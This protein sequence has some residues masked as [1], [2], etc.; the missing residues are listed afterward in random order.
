M[1][2][3]PVIDPVALQLGPL[4]IRWYALSYVVG[5]VLGYAYVV[6]LCARH[7]PALAKEAKDNLILF[8]IIGVMLGGR[9][10]YVLFYQFGY[11]LEN[12]AHILMLW[13]GGMSF[14]GGAAGVIIAFW[15]FARKYKIPYL[16]LMD[17]IVCAVPIGLF[18]GRL[19]NFINGELFGRTT[20][21]PWAMVFPR[22]GPEPRHPSQLYEAA[23]EGLL[24]LLVLYVLQRFT[25][26][27]KRHGF[28]G[29]VFLVGYGISRTVAECFREPDVQIGFLA[30]GV[31]MGQLLCVPMVLAGAWLMLRAKKT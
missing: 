23:L 14:H 21:V 4:A 24:L 19:A 17:R 27:I 9:I 20:D 1:I 3:Y 13:Q 15:F 22:G 11:F 8:A 5:I 2:D 31:T 26:A 7:G 12:P 30:G 29:G 6:K 10:G 25:P 18:L 28:L 16:M